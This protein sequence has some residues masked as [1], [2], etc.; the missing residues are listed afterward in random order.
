MKFLAHTERSEFYAPTKK[1]QQHREKQSFSNG[2]FGR[3][4]KNQ[5]RERKLNFPNVCIIFSLRI[6]PSK[7][8]SRK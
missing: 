8:H 2:N 5:E 3:Y 1:K 6:F 7:S 4:Y